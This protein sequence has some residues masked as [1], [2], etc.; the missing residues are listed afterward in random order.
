MA[1]PEPFAAAM[2]DAMQHLPFRMAVDGKAYHVKGVRQ[3]KL[4][5]YY[6]VTG[7]LRGLTVT[8]R[9]P[10]DFIPLKSSCEMCIR[11]RQ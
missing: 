1:L 5:L 3:T 2:L 11:D 10:K 7:S 4:P 9:F 8:A 6:R